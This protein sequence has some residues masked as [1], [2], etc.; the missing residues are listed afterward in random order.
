MLDMEGS[1]E[2]TALIA[3]LRAGDE[4]AFERLIREHGGRMLSVAQRYMGNC[5]DAHDAVQEAF[6]SAFRSIDRFE[7]SSLLSTWLHR[8]V[9]NACLMKLRTRRRRPEESIEELLPVFLE[10]GHHASMPSEWNE[11]CDDAYERGETRAIVRQ[12][13]DQLPE[14]YRTVLLLRDIEEVDTKETARMLG[15]TEGGAKVRLHRARQ[16]LRT[17]LD[18]RLPHLHGGAS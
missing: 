10:D 18:S 6:I 7:A 3:A 5:E 11:R 13:I 2:E 9:V 14:G 16:A 15:M 8:I 12:C 1:L 17:L 4:A